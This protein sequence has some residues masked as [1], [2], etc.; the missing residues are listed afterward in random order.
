M[1]NMLA[2]GL[3]DEARSLLPYRNHNALQTVGYKEVFGYFDGDYTYDT[4]V[5]LLKRN[6]RRYAKRQLTWFRH[7][8]EYNW[9]HADDLDGILAWCLEQQKKPLL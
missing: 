6:S 2:A 1:D 5:E 7:Q 4:M 9:F 3:V 8:V